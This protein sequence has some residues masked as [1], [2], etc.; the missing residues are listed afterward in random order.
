[1]TTCKYGAA[2]RGN[3]GGSEGISQLFFAMKIL[4]VHHRLV[5]PLAGTQQIWIDFPTRLPPCS[6]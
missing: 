2:G 5:A 6:N 4:G 3:G 1:M